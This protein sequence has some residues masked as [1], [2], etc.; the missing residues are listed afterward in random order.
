V[1]DTLTGVPLVAGR[2]PGEITPVPLAKTPVRL[3]DP[4]TVMLAGL[5]VKLAILGF[6]PDVTPAAGSIHPVMPAI[7]K[8]R[9]NAQRAMAVVRFIAAPVTEATK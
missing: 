6:V 2:L 9:E 5:A 3:V 7:H 8:L 4:P 1:G